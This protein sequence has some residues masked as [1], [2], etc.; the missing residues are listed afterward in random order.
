MGQRSSNAAVKDAQIKLGMVGCVEGTEQR[1]SG[2]AEKDALMLLSREECAVCIRH[3]A[4]LKLCSQIML[5]TQ[6][7]GLCKRHGAKEG[8]SQAMQ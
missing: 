8:K 1:A 6:H 3:G 2:A 4:K 5:S 7:G